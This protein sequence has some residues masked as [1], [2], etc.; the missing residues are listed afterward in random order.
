MLIKQDF[1]ALLLL[2]SFIEEDF[3]QE[4]SSDDASDA[5]ELTGSEDDVIKSDSGS[6]DDLAQFKNKVKVHEGHSFVEE[7][8]EEHPT[9]R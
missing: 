4:Q 3:S 7:E 9:E 2:L 5:S 8:E 1:H 6:E